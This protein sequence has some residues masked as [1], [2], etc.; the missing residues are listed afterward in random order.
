MAQ[1][2]NLWPFTAEARVRARVILCEICG[3]Q[4]RT[5]TH[6]SPNSFGFILL[7]SFRWGMNNRPVGGRSSE[8][9]SHPVD[10]SNNNNYYYL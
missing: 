1:A 10:D 2:V 4:I 7:V 6:F 8:S 9:S 5:G 3:A